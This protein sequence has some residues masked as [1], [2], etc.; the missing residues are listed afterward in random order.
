MKPRLEAWAVGFLNLEPGPSPLKAQAKPCLGPG[1]G[2][3][4]RAWLRA[5]SPARHIT[6]EY[7]YN[8]V[9]YYA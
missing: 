2:G 6:R 5:L 1:L 4:G 3:P 8:K 9:Q 7:E